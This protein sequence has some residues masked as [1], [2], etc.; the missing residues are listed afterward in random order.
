MVGRRATQLC[1][2]S[3]HTSTKQIIYTFDIKSALFGR[4][5]LYPG[6]PGSQALLPRLCWHHR[7][8]MRQALLTLQPSCQ[9]LDARL[10]AAHQ[11]PPLTT[12]INT[13]V[14]IKQRKGRLAL[15]N[16]RDDNPGG[17]PQT[18]ESGTCTAALLDPQPMRAPRDFDPPRC[19]NAA[20]LQK[21]G[22]RKESG[23][24]SSCS[25]F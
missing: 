18:L 1:A 25:S 11:P 2:R 20:V 14:S 7:Q 22:V 17:K 16:A 4:G 9:L 8:S 6:T 10:K 23:G 15:L 13:G 5:W 19:Q 12:C 24:G 21:R 3:P